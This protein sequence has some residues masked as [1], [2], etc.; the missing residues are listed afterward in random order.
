L[1]LE[2]DFKQLVRELGEAI[3][4]SL[5]ESPKVADT[6]ERIRAAGYDIFLIVEV[7]IGY[8]RHGQRRL[9]KQQNEKTSRRH[10]IQ[11]PFTAQD[12]QFLRALKIR[13][14]DDEY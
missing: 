8:E 9:T 10:Q 14:D 1:H 6:M 5:S 12:T 13:V 3:N 7:T 11:V 2:D 4:E